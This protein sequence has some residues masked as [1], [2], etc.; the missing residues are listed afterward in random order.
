MKQGQIAGVLFLGLLLPLSSAS[1]GTVL[2]SHKYAWSNNSGYINFENVVVNDSALSGYA[3]S[4]NDGFIKFNPAQGGVFNDGSGNLSGSAWGE[5]LGWIDF[6]NVS[7]NP[8]TGQFSG[9]ATGTLVGTLTF[10]CGFCDVRTDWPATATPAVVSP[11]SGGGG[12]GSYYIQNPAPPSAAHVNARNG[13]LSIVPGQSGTVTRDTSAGPV[14]LN[15]PANVVPGEAVFHLTTEVLVP[16]NDYLTANSAELINGT[17]Y[18]LSMSDP[19]G[20]PK[21][22]F[23]LPVTVTL[24][25]SHSARNRKGLGLYWLNETNQQWA[26]IPDAVFTK[27]AVT[28]QV[29]HPLKFAIFIPKPSAPRAIKNSPAVPALPYGSKPE[30]GEASSKPQPNEVGSKPQPNEVG[31][32]P[33]TGEARSKSGQ[34]NTATPQQEPKKTAV[35]RIKNFVGAIIS[36]F[37]SLFKALR[38]P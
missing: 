34:Q 14:V 11:S 33:E 8:T 19:T 25:L 21:T 24:P 17:F 4:T 23:S 15:I 13:P 38:G 20:N 31:S 9:T 1:A 5:G 36:G 35:Q 26:L 28:F 10:D 12:G 18:S 3:W 32:K 16:G 29:T 30:T 22:S 27:D 6:G 7:I 37:K 2:S